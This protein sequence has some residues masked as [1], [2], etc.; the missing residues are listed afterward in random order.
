M[1]DRNR[2]SGMLTEDELTALDDW[3][4][5]PSKDFGVT[6]ART[7]EDTQQAVGSKGGASHAPPLRSLPWRRPPCSTP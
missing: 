7:S 4:F 6:A 5:G 3:R 1:V 2:G